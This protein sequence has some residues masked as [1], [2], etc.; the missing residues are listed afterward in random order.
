[1]WDAFLL[2]MDDFDRLLEFKL[3]RMLDAIVAKPPPV[4]RGSR[5]TPAPTKIV[6][7]FS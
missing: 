2:Q 6:S 5:K 3:R 1:M 4:R 7:L